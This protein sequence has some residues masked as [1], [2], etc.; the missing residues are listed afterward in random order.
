MIFWLILFGIVT[1]NIAMKFGVPY[2]FLSPEYLGE[3]SWLSF[4]ILG[5]S[6]GGYFM[7]FHLYSYILL[8]PSFPFIATLSRPF[9]KFCLNNSVI[10]VIF[11]IVLCCN[12]FDI[13]SNEELMTGWDIFIQLLALTFGILF[14]IAL[15]VLYFFKTNWNIS[16][17]K[18]R[19][20]G[21]REKRSLYAFASTLLSKKKFWFESHHATVYRPSFYISSFR[22][23]LP[24]RDSKHYR[25]KVLKEIFRQ[26]QLNASFFEIIVIVS[27]FVLGYFGDYG[28]VQIPSGASFMLLCTLAIMIL[29]IFYSW[30][31]GWA[32]SIIAVTFIMLNVISAKTDFFQ[33]RNFAY[34]LNYSHKN[35]YNLEELNAIQFDS[36]AYEN[37][38]AH[39]EKILNRWYEKATMLQNTD[40]PKLVLVNCSGG[41]LRAAMWSF[42]VLQQ[43]DASTDNEFLDNVHMITGASGGM[44]GAAYYRE[45]A[46]QSLIEED[47]NPADDQYLQNISD[48]LLNSTSFNMVMHDVFF[49]YKSTTING[50]TY[51]QDR[52]FA[53]ESQLNVNTDYAMDKR[54]VDYR[55]DEILSNTPMMLFSPTIINDG[56][57][58]LIA[59]QPFGFMNGALDQPRQGP[60]NVEFLKLF[61]GNLPQSTKFTSVLRMNSTFPYILPMVTLPTNPEIQ[62]MDAGIRDNYGTKSTVRYIAALEEW[63]KEHTSGIVLVELRD[64]QKDYDV[65]AHNSNMSLGERFVKPLSNFYGNY[66]HSQ[67]YN[68]T[69]L[70]ESVQSDEL[71]IEVVT[72]VLRN[73][74][75]DMI[76]LS[77][78]LTQREKN[79]IKRIFNSEGNQSEMDK[80]IDLL[81]LD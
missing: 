25:R 76:S 73:D 35:D 8:G 13:Q 5:F 40:K 37:D 66:H 81:K 21:K 79:D 64:I 22:K 78:H 56:R 30:F 6:V 42:Y 26:N 62:I 44:V 63:L 36:L 38:I 65:E 49:R 43:L 52:G 71:P 33:V 41:G 55:K 39:H 29:T 58:L 57:R 51:A 67:E 61:K 50:Q 54:L 74:P 27:F 31:R 14:F 16:T 1:K 34:G 24:A 46:L 11:F 47:V 75:S 72:F 70:I 9:Y 59:S 3:V 23:I 48:D 2:L 60:E 68:A 53:F 10:P 28:L 77:W 18:L 32:V 12:I 80:L 69:E 19:S 15:S 4:F 20:K 7:A 45:I 17:M